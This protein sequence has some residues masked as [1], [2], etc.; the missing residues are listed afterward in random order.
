MYT[1]AFIVAFLAAS[2]SAVPINSTLIPRENAC[3]LHALI[4]GNKLTVTLQDA[5]QK[6]IG[7]TLQQISA[8]PAG[9]GF[10]AMSTLP[11]LVKVEIKPGVGVQFTYSGDSWSSADTGRCTSGPAPGVTGG[12]VADCGFAC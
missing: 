11:K 10:N 4:D 6:V 9:Q 7:T 8:I 2:A 1:Q 12:F 3:K 5:N